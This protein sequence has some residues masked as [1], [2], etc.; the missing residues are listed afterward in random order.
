MTS[1]CNGV[2]GVDDFYVVEVKLDEISDDIVAI[3]GFPIHMS[4]KMP[5]LLRY[6]YNHITIFWLWLWL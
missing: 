1:K 5:R 6:G 3:D 4:A 2:G